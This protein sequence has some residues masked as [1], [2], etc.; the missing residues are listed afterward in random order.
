MEVD[1]GY[2]NVHLI[3]EMNLSGFFL[4]FSSRPD[5]VFVGL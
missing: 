1:Q 3:N 2:V 5:K 4:Q